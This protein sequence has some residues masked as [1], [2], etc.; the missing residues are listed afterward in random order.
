MGQSLSDG[1]VIAIPF[2]DVV[3]QMFTE[4]DPEPSIITRRRA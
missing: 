1:R 2:F 3:I 4:Q